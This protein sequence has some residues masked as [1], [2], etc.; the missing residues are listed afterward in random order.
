MK[1]KEDGEVR[2]IS[3]GKK[4]AKIAALL[5]PFTTAELNVTGRKSHA[6][7]SDKR[8]REQERERERGAR[9]SWSNARQ[10]LVRGALY[11]WR[12]SRCLFN[13]VVHCR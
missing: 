13:S 9:S 12:R 2:L 5:S 8:A 3:G 11:T 7:Q 1:A 6:K 4:P 10:K